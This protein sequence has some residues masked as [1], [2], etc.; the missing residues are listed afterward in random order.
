[1]NSKRFESVEPAGTAASANRAAGRWN[2]C[3]SD[4][5][6]LVTL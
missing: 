5:T 3:V 4:L 2:A 6:A 1:M